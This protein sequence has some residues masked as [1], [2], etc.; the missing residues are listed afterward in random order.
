MVP[1]LFRELRLT[2]AI[3]IEY[4][5]QEFSCPLYWYVIV[6]WRCNISMFCDVQRQKYL[7]VEE[8]QG[9]KLWNQKRVC[10]K[11]FQSPDV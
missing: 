6:T 11:F 7:K 4:A 2:L 8:K 5:F 10:E 9:L 1:R 3:P